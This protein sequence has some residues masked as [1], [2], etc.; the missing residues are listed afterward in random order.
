VPV[1]V[2]VVSLIVVVVPVIVVVVS[3]TVVVMPVASCK[4]F[5]YIPF[6]LE[7]K[8]KSYNKLYH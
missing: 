6:I 8:R 1:I 2:I 4:S 3:I 5:T 7:G